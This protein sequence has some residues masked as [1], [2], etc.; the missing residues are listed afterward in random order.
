MVKHGG[1]FK[2]SKRILSHA[3]LKN[4]T[5]LAGNNDT[6]ERSWSSKVHTFNIRS[7][8]KCFLSIINLLMEYYKHLLDVKTKV[9]DRSLWKKGL[10]GLD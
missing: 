6:W 10:S 8:E 4:D 3:H 1:I 2:Q 5:I 7:S 9:R